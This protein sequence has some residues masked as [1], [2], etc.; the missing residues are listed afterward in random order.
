MGMV[1]W[2]RKDLNQLPLSPARFSNST[3][4]AL[5]TVDHK[6]V[7]SLV[8]LV[9]Q[10]IKSELWA[11][12]LSVRLSEGSGFPLSDKVKKEG[13]VKKVPSASLGV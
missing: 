12:S 3:P 9:V 2:R 8:G 7:A 4:T 1:C 5:S 13:A 10:R 6:K 11:L